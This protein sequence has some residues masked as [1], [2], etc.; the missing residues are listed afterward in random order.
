MFTLQDIIEELIEVEYG[1]TSLSM[2]LKQLEEHYE[3]ENKK[4]LSQNIIIIKRIID[5]LQ[6]DMSKS[7]EKLDMYEIKE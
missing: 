1:F 7:I 4:E 6:M 5:S 2:V 3:F